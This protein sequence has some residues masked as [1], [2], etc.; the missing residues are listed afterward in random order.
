MGLSVCSGVPLIA[1]L[2]SPALAA[3]SPSWASLMA[4]AML[5]AVPGALR[6][7]N[8]VWVPTPAVA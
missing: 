4:S 2:A 7:I 8:G 1:L 3:L 5:L 6:L